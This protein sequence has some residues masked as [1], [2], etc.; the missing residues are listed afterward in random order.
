MDL[1]LLVIGATSAGWQ[2]AV[3]A[4]QA[5]VSV[6]MIA[7]PPQPVARPSDLRQFSDEFL[8]AVCADW[9]M[10]RPLGSS[11]RRGDTAGWRQFASDAT[12]AWAH[13]QDIH[14]D[15]L[16]AAGGMMWTGS[17]ELHDGH[18]VQISDSHG[19]TLQIHSRHLLLA[20]G[21]QPQRP[22]FAA[23]HLPGVQQAAGLL[24]A[25]SIPQSACVVG[26]GVTGLRAACLLAW[27]GSQVTVVDGKPSQADLAD[28]DSAHWLQWAEDL[29]IRFECGEDAIGLHSQSAR[30]IA[31]TLESGRQLTSETVW[32]ATGRRGTTEDLHLERAALSV[33]DRGRLWC[34]DRHRTWTDSISAIGDVVGFCPTTRSESDVAN[35]I[36]QSL[37]ESACDHQ[38]TAV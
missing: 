24:D 32:L 16:L 29:D 35:D 21:T 25:S 14:R 9:P 27:W 33:D 12:R 2:G 38:L 23:Q 28:E 8:H 6:G 1:E 3:A 20:T 36:L 30:R 11:P 13:Q 19:R 15:Q 37:F 22:R 4:A 5:G 17:A 18:S 34:D 31:L 10:L 7:L 26:A